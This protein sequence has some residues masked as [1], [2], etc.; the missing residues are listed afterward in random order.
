MKPMTVTGLSGISSVYI[1]ESLK[2]LPKY[3]PK[4]DV[5]IITDENVHKLYGSLFPSDR[6]IE[7]VPGDENKN[8][9]ALVKIYDRLIELEADRSTFIAGIGGGMVCDVAGVAAS[10]YMRGLRYG[11]VATTL[12]AQVDAAIGGKNGVNFRGYKNIVGLFNQPEFVICDTDTLKTLPEREVRCGLAEAVKY[13]L[14]A[15]N[16]L[17]CYLDSNR[18]K[19]T[20]LEESTIKK[21]VCDSVR[22]KS[23][24]VNKDEK[25]HGERRKLNFGHT[26]GHAVERNYPLVHGEAVSIGMAFAADLS[27]RK[28]LLPDEEAVRIKT[29]LHGIGLPVSLKMDK[30][31]VFDSMRKDKKKEKETIRFVLLNAI[32]RATVQQM[33]IGELKE[34]FDDLC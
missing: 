21:I 23:E 13:A 28:G 5:V 6:V 25:E 19:V 22:I 30:Q 18:E 4:G 8:I 34:A 27:V 16:G 26:L 17:C 9:E 15:D 3:V 32:G 12:L 24:I 7:I 14:I 31:L 2:N 29:L 33:T 10:T 20:A 1:G 11:F